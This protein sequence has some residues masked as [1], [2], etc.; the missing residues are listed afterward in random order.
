MASMVMSHNIRFLSQ[1][2]SPIKTSVQTMVRFRPPAGARPL[3]RQNAKYLAGSRPLVGVHRCQIYDRS[4]GKYRS[5]GKIAGDSSKLQTYLAKME[6][7]FAKISWK[8]QK[9]GRISGNWPNLWLLPEVWSKP[10][11]CIF[12]LPEVWPDNWP[13]SRPDLLPEENPFEHWRNVILLI[14]LYSLPDIIS[15]TLTVI[16]LWLGAF[17]QKFTKRLVHGWENFLAALA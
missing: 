8:L 6:R 12:W 11:I 5:F 15:H 10:D 17:V 4:S 9:I 13:N 2:A 16:T 1:G 14:R 3:A 7:N